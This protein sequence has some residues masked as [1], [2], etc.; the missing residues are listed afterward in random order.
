MLVGGI[1]IRQE[2]GWDFVNDFESYCKNI[3]G[4]HVPMQNMK[5]TK[6]PRTDEGK[7]Y[8]AYKYLVDLYFEYNKSNYMFFRTLVTDR[9]KYDLEHP[10]FYDGDYE[11]GF[12][13]LYCQL[14]LYWL[15]KDIQYH[16]R[17]AQRLIKKAHA[18]DSEYLR[19][20]LLQDKLNTKFCNRISRYY[21]S[22]SL[23]PVLSI[24]PRPARDRRIIQ[25][26]DILMGAV[27]FYWNG[28]HLSGKIRK[29]KVAIAKHIAQHL[30]REDLCFETDWKDRTFNIFHFDTDKT[31]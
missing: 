12:Y 14:I 23:R 1:W 30:N 6:I 20:Q 18:H 27:G 3:I 16:I 17:L 2:K 26:A 29:G 9:N 10:V 21:P 11:K 19:L 25:I 31:K 4:I 15:E 13:N 24:E 5:W 8:E 7:Y 28:D 22:T